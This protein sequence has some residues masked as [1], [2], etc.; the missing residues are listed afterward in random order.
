MQIVAQWSE[1][2]ADNEVVSGSNPLAPMRSIHCGPGA[3]ADR[4]PTFNRQIASSN[5]V[6]PVGITA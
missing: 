5:L 3:Y 2:L 1:S 6:G 4:Q